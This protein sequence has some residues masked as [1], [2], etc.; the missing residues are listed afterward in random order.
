MERAN[1]DRGANL[2]A[3]GTKATAEEMAIAEVNDVKNRMIRIISI[4]HNY[5]IACWWLISLNKER[6]NRRPAAL[7]YLLQ[8]STSCSRNGT[9]EQDGGSTESE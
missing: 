3:D 6:G 9:N 7:W 2:G 4:G 8:P 5:M 1:V